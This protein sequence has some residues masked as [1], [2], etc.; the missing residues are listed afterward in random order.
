[1]PEESSSCDAE[2]MP[3]Y[4]HPPLQSEAVWQVIEW[5]NLM[6]EELRKRL[7]EA[8]W[9]EEARKDGGSGSSRERA[10]MG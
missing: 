9:L 3:V 8:G 6:E 4:G 5:M 1:M 2:E 10:R 7:P